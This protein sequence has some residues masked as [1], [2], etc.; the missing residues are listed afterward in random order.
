M[1][2]QLNGKAARLAQNWHVAVMPKWRMRENKH[3]GLQ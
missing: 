2:M 1:A 3:I